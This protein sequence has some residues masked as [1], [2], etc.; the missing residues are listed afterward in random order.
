VEIDGRTI[1]VDSGFVDPPG[2]ADLRTGILGY[3]E[4]ETDEDE[5]RIGFPAEHAGI[6][7]SDYD[8]VQDR[9]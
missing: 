3:S 4:D 8:T 5:D 1:E 6:L 9:P 2:T 7:W